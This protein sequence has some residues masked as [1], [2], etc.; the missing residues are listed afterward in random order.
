MFGQGPPCG[1]GV[2]G[3]VPI[4]TGG[5]GVSPLYLTARPTEGVGWDHRRAI[6][7]I[8]SAPEVKGAPSREPWMAVTRIP[9]RQSIPA[10][11]SSE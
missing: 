1:E 6:T 7:T 11:S 10:N 5:N 8:R 4:A 2:G 3:E 9:A